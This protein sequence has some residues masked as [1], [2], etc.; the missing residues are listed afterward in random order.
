MFFIVFHYSDGNSS[1][2]Y[3]GGTYIFQGEKYAVMNSD[4][5]K[6]Y[7]SEKVADRSAKRLR[8][9]CTNTGVDYSIVDFDTRQTVLK[10]NANA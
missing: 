2:V 9:S 7:K 3:G 10:G 6:L 4:S 8:G 1:E 5:P